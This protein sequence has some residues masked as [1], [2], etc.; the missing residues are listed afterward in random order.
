M[1]RRRRRERPVFDQLVA[2]LRLEIVVVIEPRRNRALTAGHESAH[3]V[4]ADLFGRVDEV[5]ITEDAAGV[6]YPL[7]A[8]GVVASADPRA[9][10]AREDAL[11]ALAGP[12]CEGLMLSRRA[13]VGTGAADDLR[14]AWRILARQAPEE[15]AR[16]QLIAHLFAQAQNLVLLHYLAIANVAGHLLEQH[17]LMAG[18]AQR[19]LRGVEPNRAHVFFAELEGR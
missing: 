19:I 4:V 9:D 18:Q 5:V 16:E 7:V 6:M 15:S 13:L 11:V 14:S 17:A 2:A 1:T 3:V 12:A 10:R 8:P